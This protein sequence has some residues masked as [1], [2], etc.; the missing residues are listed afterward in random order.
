[1]AKA[2]LGACRGRLAE[3]ARQLRFVV[4]LVV[5]GVALLPSLDT[6]SPVRVPVVE[7]TGCAFRSAVT[8]SSVA[9]RSTGPVAAAGATTA[10]RRRNVPVVSNEKP[11]TSPAPNARTGM[12][13]SM[14][15]TSPLTWM[16][17]VHAITWL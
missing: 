8:G 15:V 10:P 17:R 16:S 9:R 7:P 4:R 14:S 12:Y 13:V 11:K 6:G 3:I 2:V 1:R 5:V